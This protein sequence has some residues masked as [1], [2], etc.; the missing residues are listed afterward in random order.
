MDFFN[1]QDFNLHQFRVIYMFIKATMLKDKFWV[2]LE[3]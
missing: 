2:Y 3:F 1:S